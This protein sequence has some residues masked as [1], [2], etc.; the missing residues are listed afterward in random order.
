MWGLHHYST[1]VGA[2]V[3]T[4]IHSTPPPPLLFGPLLQALSCRIT[5]C[6]VGLMMSNTSDNP[7][8]S[9]VLSELFECVVQHKESSMVK[10]GLSLEQFVS[11]GK[12]SDPRAQTKHAATMEEMRVVSGQG[13]GGR[14]DQDYGA[15]LVC[16]HLPVYLMLLFSWTRG[17]Y[18]NTT[19]TRGTGRSTEI[20]SSSGAYLTCSCGWSLCDQLA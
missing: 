1:V 19:H 4:D 11:G 5:L 15:I 9:N 18:W 3:C 12:A 2:A 17:H 8:L 20:S 6:I 13:P 7:G 14:A 10:G 16:P